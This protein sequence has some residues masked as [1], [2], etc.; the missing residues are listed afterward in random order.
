MSEK[1]KKQGLLLEIILLRFSF[2][3]ILPQSI[4]KQI[5]DLHPNI[6]SPHNQ[7]L[8]ALLVNYRVSTFAFFPKKKDMDQ[9]LG[10][11]YLEEKLSFRLILD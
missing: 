10:Q 8:L 11:A 2:L 1:N 9:F 4:K 3:K 5:K 7:L 6:S